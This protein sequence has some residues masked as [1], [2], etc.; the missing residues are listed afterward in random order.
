LIHESLHSIRQLNPELG[1]S[2]LFS[3]PYVCDAIV[4]Y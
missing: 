1:F 3:R 2:R 4:Y